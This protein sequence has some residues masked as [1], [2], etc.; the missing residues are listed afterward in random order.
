MNR[1]DEAPY[2]PGESGRYTKGSPASPALPPDVARM[3]GGM[4]GTLADVLAHVVR[5]TFG[6]RRMTGD[7][8]L[9]DEVNKG[10]LYALRHFAAEFSVAAQARAAGLSKFH[11]TRKFRGETGITPG[12]FV[13]RCRLVEAMR[14]L[15]ETQLEI[16]D[17]ALRVGY[18]NHAAFTRAFTREIGAS[19]RVW[20]R[21]QRIKGWSRAAAEDTAPYRTEGEAPTAEA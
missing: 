15:T 3:F 1:S 20:R 9:S 13:R 14:L 11:F 8:P 7:R 5:R 2:E 6:R 10:I 17:V 19:P 18:G 16:S 21:Q 12:E 4:E